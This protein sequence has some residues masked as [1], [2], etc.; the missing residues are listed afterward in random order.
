M[1]FEEA[2]SALEIGDQATVSNGLPEPVQRG[3]GAWRMWRS[4]N[5]EGTLTA[6]NDG[7]HRS[8]S[9][10]L[11]PENGATVSYTVLEATGNTYEVAS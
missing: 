7:V 5:F 1:T 2:W 4:H 6:K 3:G 9:F 11:A 10:Q 8:M